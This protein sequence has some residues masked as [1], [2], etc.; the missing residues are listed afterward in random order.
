MSVPARARARAEEL[1]VELE[2]HNRL[3]YTE[4]AP[5]ISDAEYDRLFRELQDLEAEHAELATPDSPTQRVGAPLAEGE[6]FDKV[7][8]AEP[9][10]SIDSLFSEEEVLEFVDRIRRFLKLDEGESL[11]WSVEPKFD[12]VSA[13]LIYEDGVLVRCL[14]RGDGRV[15]ED[16]TQNL[17]TVRN[18]PLRL[19]GSGRPV[20]E[21]LEVRGEV[22]IA[23][24]RFAALNE[25]RT[26]EGLEP[27]ANPRNTASGAMRRNDPAEVAR[28]PL[29]FHAYAAPRCTGYEFKTQ[30]EQFEALAGWGIPFSSHG[31]MVVGVEAC[32]AYQREMEA[33]RDD[34]PFEVDGVVAKLDDLR[35]RE[36]LGKTARAHRWQYAQKFAPR[37]ATTVLRAIEVSVGTNGRLTP[38]AHVDPV[39]VGGVTVRHTTLHNAEYVEALGVKI[40]D[41]VFLKRAGDVIPQITGLA[42]SGGSRAPKGWSEGIPA[43][44]MDADGEPRV[45]MFVAFGEA[46][47]PPRTCPACGTEAEQ[48]GKY[49][50]C[51]NRFGCEPQLVGRTWHLAGRNAFEID[52]IGEK[53]LAQLY[54]AG[55][56]AGPADLFHLD[57]DP[58]KREVLIGLERWGEKSVDNLFAQLEERRQVPFD[59]YLVGLCIPEVGGATARLLAQRFETPAALLEAEEEQLVEI[60]GIGPEVARE[61][62]GWFE[63]AQN[64][65]MLERLEAGGV[66]VQA[67]QAA[68]TEGAFAG[69]IVVFTG[70]LEGM[71]RA[72]AKASVERQGGKVASSV[73]KN[74]DFLIVGGKPG[75]KAK[76]AEEIGV[77]VLL[78]EAFLE[79]LGG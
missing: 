4:S 67:V 35:L 42:K 50:Q 31:R 13:A 26:A 68:A 15:G 75:S 44:L 57:R 33:G 64:R 39:E 62:L 10:I 30:A 11:E 55:L 70:T 9:M 65:A 46:F 12:G 19:D 32:L 56:L 45:G 53:Q 74:T 17:R 27:F 36:R 1:R 66:E 48:D 72:E 78:E 22:L 52:R 79:R 37:E 34:L 47:H 54:E 18:I 2:R 60:D 8:H 38:R 59:R 43:D 14:T 23:L 71:T 76:K 3:Y 51:P 41:R 61:I 25:Q 63:G 77:T 29:E 6:T 58:E 24:E 7:A 28:Y 73:S 69:S 49:W 20:P 5:E 16:V 21:L 40:G